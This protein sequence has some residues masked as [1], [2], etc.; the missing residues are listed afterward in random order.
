MDGAAHKLRGN[1]AKA[2]KI[3]QKTE[4]P[5]KLKELQARLGI[6]GSGTA[7][8]LN[9]LIKMGLAEKT[10]YGQYASKS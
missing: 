4:G 1:G 7:S 6:S 3:L 9:R 10:G 8:I 5:I 2:L